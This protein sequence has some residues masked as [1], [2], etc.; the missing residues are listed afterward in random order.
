MAKIV[1]PAIGKHAK[2]S[3]CK[4]VVEYMPE[5]IQEHHGTDYGGGPSG[6]KR[7]KCPR[8]GCPGYAYEASW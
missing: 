1:E 8:P 6:W 4:A 5:E 2:C 7:V 3:A